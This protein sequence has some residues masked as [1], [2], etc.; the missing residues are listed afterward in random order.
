VATAA[1]LFLDLDGTLY[2]GPEPLRA[3][4][5]AMAER[6][7]GGRGQTLAA[8]AEAF[9][10]DPRPFVPFRDAWAAISAFGGEAG[11]DWPRRDEA[12]L[13]VR[14]AIIAGRVPIERTPG[15][16]AFV[17]SLDGRVRVAVLTNSDGPSAL[18]LLGYLELGALRAH[19][20]AEAN[21][22]AG[23]AAAVR[24]HLRGIGAEKAV[25]VGD[26]Q[27][28]DIAP[29]RALGMATVHVRWPEA[30]GGLAD[31]SVTVLEDAF[32]A[33]SCHLE[34]ALAGRRVEPAT[35]APA[36]AQGGNPTCA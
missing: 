31:L 12:F 34:T 4:A 35:D 1:A 14:A 22:P 11:L 24:D 36:W 15:L 3:Y 18:D 32:D 13:D 7:G 9:L 20:R 5:L 30:E 2:R 16:P 29:A 27:V 6:A 17:R 19:L 21:K 28:N 10:A 33:L 25:S 26:N 8:K 23:F